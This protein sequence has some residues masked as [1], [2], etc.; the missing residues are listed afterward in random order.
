MQEIVTSKNKKNKRQL[1]KDSLQ[2]IMY[3]LDEWEINV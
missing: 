1:F 2:R 3:V